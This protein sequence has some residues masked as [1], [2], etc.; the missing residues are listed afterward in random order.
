MSRL[1][2][3]LFAYTPKKYAGTVVAYEATKKPLLHLPQVARVWSSLAPRAT[4]VRVK[5]THLSILRPGDVEALAKDL[6]RRI[7]DIAEELPE[8]LPVAAPAAVEAPAALDRKS[9]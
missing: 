6:Q 4:I 9:A 2:A 7:T 1:Y 8:P 5:G 3:A